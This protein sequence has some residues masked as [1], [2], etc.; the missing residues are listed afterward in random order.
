MPNHYLEPEFIREL[1]KPAPT[2]GSA[3]F[4]SPAKN[5]GDPQGG[6]GLFNSPINSVLSRKFEYV[7]Y[8]YVWE[9]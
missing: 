4:Y 6:A 8:Y 7:V 5:L 1:N 9:I 2:S 3:K